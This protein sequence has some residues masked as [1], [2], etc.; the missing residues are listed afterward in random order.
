MGRSAHMLTQVLK[1]STPRKLTC[2]APGA[3]LGSDTSRSCFILMLSS[4]CREGAHVWLM[5]R[6]Y[7]REM[8]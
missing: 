1:G 8:Q 3:P 5:A 7:G 6:R 2:M 4:I